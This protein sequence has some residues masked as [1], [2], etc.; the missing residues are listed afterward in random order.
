MSFSLWIMDFIKS[1]IIETV[2][3]SLAVIAGLWISP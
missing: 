2:I 1:F 3:L